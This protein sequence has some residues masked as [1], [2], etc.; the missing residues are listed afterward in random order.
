[1]FG[2][3]MS[4]EHEN[5]NFETYVDLLFYLQSLLVKWPLNIDM[6]M[7]NIIIYTYNVISSGS[8]IHRR[9]RNGD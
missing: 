2:G 9:K 6:R 7:L 8:A 4:F 3:M 1:M 5:I